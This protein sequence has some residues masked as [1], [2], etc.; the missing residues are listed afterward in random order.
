MY[1]GQKPIIK[2]KKKKKKKKKR[3]RV[4]KGRVNSKM[5]EKLI[6]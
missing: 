4:K 6:K 5:K 2:K 1:K 3:G